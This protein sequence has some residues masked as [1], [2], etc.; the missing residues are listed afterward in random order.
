MHRPLASLLALAT[1]TA[2]VA[3]SRTDDMPIGT[4]SGG[5][6]NV[7][8]P[9][10]SAGARDHSLVRVAN[11]VSGG[12]EVAML[13]DEQPLFDAVKPNAVTDYREV[14]TNL[15][16]FSVRRPVPRTASLSTTTTNC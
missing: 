15:A 16:D 2:F 12:T 9:A 10:D 1:R 3:S 13:T 5:E 14:S 11:A 7:S 8:P 6:A 4:T